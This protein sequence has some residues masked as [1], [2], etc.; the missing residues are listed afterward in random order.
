M[1]PRRLLTL[2]TSGFIL[3][4]LGLSLL[5]LAPELCLFFRNHEDLK[6]FVPV[7]YYECIVSFYLLVPAWFLPRFWSRLWVTVV[8]SLSGLATLIIGFQ[9]FSIGA[10][11]DIVAH[12]ALLQTSPGEAWGYL[13][14]FVSAGALLWTVALG[15][16]FAACIAINFRSPAPSRRVAFTGVFLGLLVSAYGLHNAIRYGGWL[17]RTVPVSGGGTVRTIDGSINRLHP[18]TLLAMTHYN[19]HVTHAYYLQAFHDNQSHLGQFKGAVSVPGAVSPRIVLVIIGESASRRHWSLYGYTRETTPRLEELG[20]E[21]LVFRD[22]ISSSTGTLHELRSM[23]CTD[24]ASLPV[25]PLFSAAGYMTHWFSAQY[26]QGANDVESAALVQSCDQRLF[27]NGAYDEALLPLV[28]QAVATPGKHVIFVN[29]FGSHVRYEDRYP[30][31][32]AVFHGEGEKGHRLATYD[33]SIRYTDHVLAKMIELLRQRSEPNCLLYLSDHSEDVYDSQPDQYLFRSDSVATDA[34]YEIPFVVWFS[35]EYRQANASFVRLVTAA[36]T[37]KYQT[38]ALY[39]SLIDLT[40]L[41][42]PIYDSRVSLFSPDY[43]E[44]DRRVGVMGRLYGSSP[45]P[46]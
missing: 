6:Y 8:G 25:F 22:V 28:Q 16:G 39:Q 44:R 4:L 13:R 21:V 10:R 24:V 19:Y 33:N 40:R 2:G 46:P 41:T 17:F 36:R 32:F 23:W 37:R 7:A 5:P 31:S 18:V 27:L 35:P 26:S 11:W 12:A 43:V 30:G 15:A 42:H 38:R 1:S 45:L 20:A 9:A 34:M 3:S 14:S 29:L